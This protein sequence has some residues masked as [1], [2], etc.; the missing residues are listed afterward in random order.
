MW[1]LG[2]FVF[3]VVIAFLIYCAR[4]STLVCCLY[5]AEEH[6]DEINNCWKKYGNKDPYPYGSLLVR[7]V[8]YRKTHPAK[9]ECNDER[10]A[11]NNVDIFGYPKSSPT[12]K[13]EIENTCN[14]DKNDM[15]QMELF[16]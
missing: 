12:P 8:T 3:I 9:E 11:C 4:K 7:D 13:P 10:D 5:T 15:N 2:H 14:N 1:L 6:K 16:D